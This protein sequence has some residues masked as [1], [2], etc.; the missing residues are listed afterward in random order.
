MLQALANHGEINHDGTFNRDQLT[1]ALYR[2]TGMCVEQAA[3]QFDA[4][5][6][7]D[8]TNAGQPGPP[9]TWEFDQSHMLTYVGG[10]RDGGIAHTDAIWGDPTKF[11]ATKMTIT[12][13]FSS[14]GTT[15][16]QW[17]L[18][19]AHNYWLNISNFDHNRTDPAQIQAHGSVG[20][21][22]MANLW[23]L[24][25]KQN[26]SK[27]DLATFL[28]GRFP[29]NFTRPED[30]CFRDLLQGIFTLNTFGKAPLDDEL[31]Y[32]IC[33]QALIGISAPE[34]YLCETEFAPYFPP[35]APRDST[36]STY[37]NKPIP[38]DPGTRAKAFRMGAQF[39]FNDPDENCPMDAAT[40]QAARLQTIQ[41]Y[42]LA[43]QTATNNYAAFEAE[44]LPLF[45]N[46]NN[47]R[48]INNA[49]GIFSSPKIVAE[50]TA[51]TIPALNNGFAWFGPPT[52]HQETFQYFP[53]NATVITDN[54]QLVAFVCT[55]LPIVNPLTGQV[56]SDGK[57]ESPLIPAA[58][59]T[60]ITFVP[61]SPI[62]KQ[63]IV[64]FDDLTEK[65]AVY[66]FSAF[67]TCWYHDRYCTGKNRQYNSYTDCISF[68]NSVPHVSC[69]WLL[70]GNSQQCRGLHAFLAKLDPDVH[71]S[72]IG[73][74][75]HPC[76]DETCLADAG[77]ELLCDD[78][79]VTDIRYDAQ[80]SVNC[81]TTGGGSMLHS[82]I[83]LSL[84]ALV[85]LFF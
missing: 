84:L 57:C 16:G 56:F 82:N 5:W 64:A 65:M 51:L 49:A 31:L 73:P 7:R 20:I 54:T 33:K 13:S 52:V 4:L 11:N 35:V 40:L 66:G 55:D 10:E 69:N 36:L 29:D 2:V 30:W 83:L 28:S 47:S 3:T 38:L 18:L 19:A 43:T 24:F 25:G 79:D 46:D 22:N 42:F 72:H 61:C 81:T 63:F 58:Q 59:S 26:V 39:A 60:M 1:H 48:I 32:L 71:C 62:M 23:I 21:L 75:S 76:S 80:K 74:D 14:D 50:Y 68:M 37:P 41:A 9:D 6:I 17:D 15:M 67:R 27:T 78:Y 85:V 44:L 12:N 8:P 70:Q 34:S 53:N 45:L 77:G